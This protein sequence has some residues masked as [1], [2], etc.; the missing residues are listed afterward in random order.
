MTLKLAHPI[1]E[2]ERSPWA[3]K[4]H[5]ACMLVGKFGRTTGQTWGCACAT[6]SAVND[7]RWYRAWPVVSRSN[8]K[9]TVAAPFSKKR[10]SGSAV[11]TITGSV[12]GLLVGNSEGGDRH[13]PFTDVTYCI[14]MAWVLS[15]LRQNGIDVRLL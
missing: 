13:F 14:P 6:V 2:M 11:F 3:D 12:G 10:D 8:K 4:R 15:D 7:G 5:D 1:S 9:G